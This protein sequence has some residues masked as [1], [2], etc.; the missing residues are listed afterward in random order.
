M[1]SLDI[2]SNSTTSKRYTA[3]IFD[4]G[5]V[6]FTWSLPATTSLPAK[7]IGNILRS[8][9]WLEYEKGN[10]TQDETYSLVAQQFCVSTVDVRN[11]IEAAGSSLEIDRKDRKS[12][13]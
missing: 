5:D 4:L 1:G 8:V 11:S 2:L 12:V 7:T 6:L 10:L 13:V 3:V 9:H